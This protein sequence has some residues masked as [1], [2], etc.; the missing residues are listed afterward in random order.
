MDVDGIPLAFDI[1][2]GN[3]SE[4]ETLQPIEDRIAYDFECSKFIVC[5]DAGLSSIENRKFNNIKDRAF[6]T[7]QSIKKLKKYLK[8][9]ALEKTGWHLSGENKTYD[10]SMFDNNESA[11]KEF[12]N[13]VF[14]K[15]R[16][17]NDNGLEQKLIVTFL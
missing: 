7:T 15:E 3:K 9:W 8:E 6:I 14:Y 16:W 11:T 12:F 5:T 4:Q 10:I 1:T 2:K 13:K 17:I